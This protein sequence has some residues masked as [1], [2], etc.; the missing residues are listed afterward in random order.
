MAQ[1]QYLVGHLTLLEQNCDV[2]YAPN[3]IT[4]AGN[5]S[6]MVPVP[7]VMADIKIPV[8]VNGMRPAVNL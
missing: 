8:F 1:V 4:R 7:S 3:G 5:V 2:L 6:L